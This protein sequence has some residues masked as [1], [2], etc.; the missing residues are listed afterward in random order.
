LATFP[1]S[2]AAPLTLA[3]TPRYPRP[4]RLKIS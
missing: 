1:A 4:L 3:L 2:R